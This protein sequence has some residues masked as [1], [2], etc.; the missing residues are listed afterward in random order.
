MS[1]VLKPR[2]G[3][4][5]QI[6]AFIGE[7]NEVVLNTT[8]KTLHVM[9]GVTTGGHELARQADLE[10]VITETST[11]REDTITAAQQAS[12]KS[13]GQAGGVTLEGVAAEMGLKANASL[14]NL[15]AAGRSLAAGL[16]MPSGRRVYLTL[17]ASG[18]T[19]TAPAN[20]FY[21]LDIA[22]ANNQA[23]VWAG[24]N[25]WFDGRAA[26]VGNIQ[27][28]SPA[29]K[30]GDVMTLYYTNTGAVAGFC[31]IYAEGEEA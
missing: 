16:G 15:S 1:K 26:I 17:G 22:T 30:K 6:A 18:T 29:C 31:F 24:G 7:E 27:W 14:D 9:D 12:E 2:R 11:I 28:T 3:S 8:R 21:S 5:E 19:Y 13:A 23:Q 25:Y 20:G 10:P 4:A